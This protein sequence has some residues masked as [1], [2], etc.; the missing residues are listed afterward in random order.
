MAHTSC[1]C[2]V[3][4]LESMINQKVN[5]HLLYSDYVKYQNNRQN[6]CIL[7]GALFTS[8]LKPLM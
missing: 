2:R 8:H 4:C 1:T 7:P 3:A 5:M 6:S